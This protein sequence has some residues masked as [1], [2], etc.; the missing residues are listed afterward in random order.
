MYAPYKKHTQ[1]FGNVQCPI[2]D[3]QIMPLCRL[4]DRRGRKTDLYW[5]LKTSN[6]AYNDDVT[7]SQARDT[8]HRRMQEVNSLCTD[9]GPLQAKYCIVGT[10]QPPYLFFILLFLTF[11]FLCRA[12]D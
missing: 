10:T 7:Q 8:K 2:L 12:L 11:S 6:T 1:I 9:S 4:A 3:K 5:K